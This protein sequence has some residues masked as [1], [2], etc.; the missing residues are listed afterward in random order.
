MIELITNGLYL[1]QEENN[2]VEIKR[3]ASTILMIQF[4]SNVLN[5]PQFSA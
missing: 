5:K 2:K 3:A 1:L 4:F